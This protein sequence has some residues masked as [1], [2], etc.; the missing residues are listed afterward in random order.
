MNHEAGVSVSSQGKVARIRLSRPPL[1]I[2][3]LRMMEDLSGELERL[4]EDKGVHVAVLESAIPGVF[5]AG[6][7]V[8]EHLPESAEL[9]ISAFG[10]LATR[11]ISLQIPTVAVVQG[12]CL[13]GGMEL[14][15]ACDFVIADESATFGQPEVKVGVYPPVAAALYPRMAGLRSAY[16][17]LLTGETFTAREAQSM[18]LVTEVVEGGRLES[19]VGKLLAILS[20]QSRAVLEFTKRAINENISRPLGEAVQNSSRLYLEGLMKTE[21]ASEGLAAFLE[22]RKPRWR[23]G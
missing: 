18:G 22:K 12:K 8:K 2:L 15:L 11:L 13:G 1:N 21:D 20:E 19:E 14:A 23:D 3:N 9:L 6:A 16:R 7:D 5:S 4:A 17:V 10:R